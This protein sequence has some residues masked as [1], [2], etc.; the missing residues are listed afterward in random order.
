M[1]DDYPSQAALDGLERYLQHEP[2]NDTQQPAYAYFLPDEA[3]EALSQK[4]PLP[5][6]GSYDLDLVDAPDE[7]NHMIGAVVLTD[8]LVATLQAGKVAW[9]DVDGVPVLIRFACGVEVER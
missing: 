9:L 5:E 6:L 8:E 1:P 2:E 7:V 4:V 3:I